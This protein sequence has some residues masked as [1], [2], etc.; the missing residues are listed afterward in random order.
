MTKQKSVLV[1]TIGTR[2]VAFCSRSGEWLNIGN[3]FTSINDDISEQLQV[4]ID[5]GLD[6]GNFRSITKYLRD[7]WQQYQE[8]LKP[9]IIGQMLQDYAKEIKQIYLIGTDQQESVRQRDRDTIHS[10]HIIDQW[11]SKNYQIPTKIILQ[12]SEGGNP[13]DFEQMFRWWKQAWREEI[14]PN[15]KEGTKFLLCLKGGVGSFSEAARISALS[16]FGE[17]SQ[18][19]DFIQDSDRNRQG[20]ASAYTPPAKGTNYLWDR[21]QQEALALLNRYDYEGVNRVL[22]PYYRYT[23]DTEA[24]NKLLLQTKSSLEAAIVWNQ[25]N[26]AEFAKLESQSKN[27]SE[28]W[29]WTGYEAAYLGLIRYHQDNTVEALFHSFRA[30]EGIM[31]DWAIANFSQDIVTSKSGTGFG[32]VPLIKRSI[33]QHQG[34]QKYINQFQGKSQVPLYGNN[35]DNLVQNAKPEYK[36][37][38]DIQKFWYV[39][40]DNRNQVFH[41]LLGLDKGDLFSAWGTS[42]FKEWQ[43]RVLG[44]LNFI[45][46]KNYNSL[47]EASLMS[48]VH[49]E[50][51]DSISNYQPR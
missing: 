19:F 27:I 46:G 48:K 39:A 51:F 3:A 1:A 50:L 30:V 34:L 43:S 13:A 36:Q 40:K 45:S 11:I 4:Q 35:L 31:S 2:D 26:F 29:W 8:R 9:I 7:N 5:L 10:A 16:R 17:D 32:K 23:D 20:K 44:C 14:V 25:A 49:Q 22:R 47:S 12:G 24:N 41:R 28:Q 6:N 37:C 33:T 42:S 21:Q 38:Q 15:I 18:F